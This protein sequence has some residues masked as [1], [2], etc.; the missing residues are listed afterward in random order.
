[1]KTLLGVVLLIDVYVIVYYR[2]LVKYHYE[3]ATG[4]KESAFGALFSLPPYA[5]LTER[6]RRYARRYWVAVAVMVGCVAAMAVLSD[7]SV[8]V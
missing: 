8:F 4:L 3:Q 7:F 5:A 6:G 2:L 1:M